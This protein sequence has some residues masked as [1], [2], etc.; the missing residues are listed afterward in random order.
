VMILGNRFNQEIMV[1]LR[2]PACKIIHDY[3]TEKYRSRWNKGATEDACIDP[4]I[5]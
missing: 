3:G 2:N 5:S 4:G 1:V